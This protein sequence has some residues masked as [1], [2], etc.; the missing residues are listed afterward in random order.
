[1][2]LTTA[3]ARFEATDPTR[4]AQTPRADLWRVQWRGDVAVLKLLTDE[5]M[6]ANEARAADLLRI[7]DGRG[8]VRL[9]D[10]SVDGRAQLME[11]LDGPLLGDIARDGDDLA[12]AAELAQVAMSLAQ[13]SDPRF[14]DIETYG[15]AL[16]MASPTL[17]P[18]RH[19]ATFEAARS[20]FRHLLDTTTEQRLLHGDLHHDNIMRGTRGWAA[21]DPK[22]I[23]GDPHYEFA[24]AFR[25]PEGLEE[26]CAR[27]ERFHAY[28]ET[29]AK[30]TGLNAARLKQWAF[31]HCALS[32]SWNLERG[33]SPDDDLV[34]LTL[35]AN[36]S[37][38]PLSRPHERLT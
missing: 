22:G 35:F 16:L 7:W 32:I 37:D 5:G 29:F 9:L 11:Y 20:M 34:L 8:A 4:L 14:P 30:A 2:E 1:M 10:A 24:N 25:N 23:N 12:A 27:P 15:A 19:R 28:A 3:L 36:L 13:P 21:I 33:H 38:A 18:A 17:F 6:A 31:A 26:D